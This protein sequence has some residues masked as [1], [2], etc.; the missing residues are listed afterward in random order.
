MKP[1][2]EE[3]TIAG[4]TIFR[5]LGRLEPGVT[6]FYVAFKGREVFKAGKY[7]ACVHWLKEQ[8]QEQET[9][10]L[11]ITDAGDRSVGIKPGQ[12]FVRLPYKIGGDDER[13]SV[14]RH[15]KETFGEYHQ[16]PV[17]VRF[18]DECPDCGAIGYLFN[19]CGNANCMSNRPDNDF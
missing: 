7:A 6:R 11:T 18:N 1:A 4:A 13:A 10:S 3:K 8:A 9:T 12:T 17:G 2:I 14:R 5:R 19:V 15:M 16:L